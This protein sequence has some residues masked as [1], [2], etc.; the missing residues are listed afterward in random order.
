VAVDL[1]NCIPDLEPDSLQA[2]WLE[3]WTAATQAGTVSAYLDDGGIVAE[4][5]AV[6]MGAAAYMGEGIKRNWEF[7][8]YK[9]IL[10]GAWYGVHAQYKK[11]T[12][13]ILAEF[14]RFQPIHVYSSSMSNPPL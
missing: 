2:E 11:A 10:S 8:N 1:A 14:Q 5:R 7:V 6:V 3:R 4:M 9:T 12:S 13:G